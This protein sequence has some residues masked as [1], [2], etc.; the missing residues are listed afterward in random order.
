MIRLRFGSR[1]RSLHRSRARA[2]AK[3]IA[4]ES[5]L[6]RQNEKLSGVIAE[7]NDEMARLAELREMATQRREENRGI[8]KRIAQIIRG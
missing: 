5:R 4:T 6:E 7:L 1:I 2:I 8:I 3:F